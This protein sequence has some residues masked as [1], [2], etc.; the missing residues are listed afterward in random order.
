M[1]VFES[2][3][4]KNTKLGN[5]QNMK[6]S[7]PNKYILTIKPK[8]YRTQ[9][10]SHCGVYS[11]KAILNAYGLDNKTHPKYYHPNLL[12]RITG[13]TLGKNYNADIL[14]SYGIQAETKTAKH[15]SNL[16]KIQILKEILSRDTPVM[17][18]IGNGYLSDKYNPVLGKIIGHWITLWGYDDDKQIFYVYDSGLQKKYWKVNIPIGNTI[19]TYEEILRDWNFGNIQFWVW[20]FSSADTFLYIQIENKKYIEP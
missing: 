10:L 12:G 11:I 1:A 14:R 3:L 16:E 4:V 6:T 19:R 18:R 15:H 5:T 20:P 2:C 8:E 13:L 9:G 17:L 7:H